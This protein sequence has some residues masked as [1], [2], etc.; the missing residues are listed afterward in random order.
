MTQPNDVPDHI[1]KLLSRAW[2]STACYA[3]STDRDPTPAEVQH[4]LDRT[5]DVTNTST[6]PEALADLYSTAMVVIERDRIALQSENERLRSQI[7]GMADRVWDAPGCDDRP[8]HIVRLLKR[9]REICEAENIDVSLQ[10]SEEFVEMVHSNRELAL[11][12][13]LGVFAKEVYLMGSYEGRTVLCAGCVKHG[14]SKRSYTYEEHKAHGKVCP[15]N[16]WRKVLEAIDS[17]YVEGSDDAPLLNE[18]RA[19]AKEHA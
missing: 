12:G 7:T 15:H 9:A 13:A 18:I 8:P 6:P 11:M 2:L 14:G 16:D 4:I 3:V 5:R 10:P 17:A 1:A 19:I